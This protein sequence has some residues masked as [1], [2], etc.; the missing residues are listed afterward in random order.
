MN[1]SK[2][3]KNGEMEKRGGNIYIYNSR[4]PNKSK[5]VNVALL[6]NYAS[7]VHIYI[8]LSVNSQK[9]YTG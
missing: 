2:R 3:I 5:H 7:K 8:Q 1:G 9:S 6:D 4:T